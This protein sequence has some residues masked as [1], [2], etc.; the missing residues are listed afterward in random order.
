MADEKPE[1]VTGKLSGWIKAGVTS[2][3]GLLSGAVLMYATAFVN[4]TIK[5]AKPVANFA[6]Q[7]N[8]LTVQF[9]NRS[10]GATHGWWDFG[11][12]TALEPFDPKSEI[13][14]HTY[15][16]PGTYQVRLALQNLLSETGDRSTP[17]TLDVA[18]VQPPE[19]SD[20][21]IVTISERAPALYQLKTTVKNAAF[22]VLTA[23]DDRP[24]EIIDNPSYF[25]R[26]LKFDEM[27]AYTVRF[28]A[29]NGKKLVEK[30]KTIF[31]NPDDSGEAMAKLHVSYEAI[32][33]ET[34]SRNW[35]IG[36]DWQSGTN[37]NSAFF[38]KERPVHFGF[39]IIKAEL[40]N[41]NEPD[42]PVRN[43]NVEIAPDQSKLILTG[44]L[45]K[46]GGLLTAN[47]PPPKW[48]ANVNVVMERR[49]APQTRNLGDI[50]LTVSPN[51]TIRL[52][53]Q[54][55]DPGWEILKTNISLE[56]WDGTRKVWDGANG[57]QN[58]RVTVKNQACYLTTTIQKD[59]VIVRID[60]PAANLLP[61]SVM[62]QPATPVAPPSPI[63]PVL[64]PVSFERN[65]LLQLWP[66]N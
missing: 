33:V 25:E 50:A 8:G 34:I 63:G 64:R 14:K 9:N 36:C 28:A 7:V 44:E 62:M 17:I 1:S 40:L 66:K 22:C 37:E 56:L 54:S 20:F 59:A 29:V 16:K 30:N 53:I 55:L 45:L 2:M 26:Y 15:V 32:Q 10:T 24:I 6:T 42:A 52:P 31:V 27:G 41:K 4:N 49:S 39:K 61:K 46:S 23:G 35:K 18:E 58:T 3:I 60:C 48:L 43:A 65:P 47:E 13:I 57:C 12:G 19:I 5:P 11:D 38:R 51:S 21:S